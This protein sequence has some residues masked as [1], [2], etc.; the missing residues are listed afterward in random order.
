MHSWRIQCCIAL[1]GVCVAD[2]FAL[3]GVNNKTKIATKSRVLIEKKL[4]PIESRMS[5]ALDWRMVNLTAMM[6]K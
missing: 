5:L 6:H 4:G 3:Y 2:I 1:F